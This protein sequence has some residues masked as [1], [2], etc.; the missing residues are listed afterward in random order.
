MTTKLNRKDEMALFIGKRKHCSQMLEPEI[1]GLF[2]RLKSVEKS[3]RK[4]LM[5]GHALDR[6]HEKGI[7]ATYDDVVSTIH[8][9]SIV[10]YKI[11]ENK[12]TG[13][14]EERVVLR[15]NAIVN[16]SYNL[17]VVYSLSEGRIITVW[18][19]HI[20]DYHS[21]LDWSIYSSE[22]KVFGI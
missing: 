21:T 4:W 2:A 11:D 8:N 12:F 10:E 20:K 13:R 3:G 7:N 22:M 14:A 15:A 19:N 9:A 17:H 18:I 6:L 16:R 1:N 5:A